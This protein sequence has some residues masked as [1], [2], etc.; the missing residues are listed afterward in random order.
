MN[1]KAATYSRAKKSQFF[2]ISVFLLY[3]TEDN[4]AFSLT[5]PWLYPESLGWF[6][7]LINLY[8]EVEI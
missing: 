1:I 4:K 5:R 6:S 7:Q 8:H 3:I 2:G